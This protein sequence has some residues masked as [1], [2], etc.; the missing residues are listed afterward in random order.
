[1]DGPTDVGGLPLD[2]TN[3]TVRASIQIASGISP[4]NAAPFSAVLF[5]VTGKV[6]PNNYVWGEGAWVNMDTV[7][8]WNSLSLNMV[9]PQAV[10]T[11]KVYDPTT[12][13]QL[14]IQISTG[15]GGESSYCAQ[16]YA[17]PF[18][19]PVSSVIY[20]DQITVENNP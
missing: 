7:G 6:A 2:L 17:S 15:G 8:K 1:M 19:S 11:G 13:V 10:P 18:G 4:N 12:P 20:I 3:K 5:V 9:A 14:G 16:D